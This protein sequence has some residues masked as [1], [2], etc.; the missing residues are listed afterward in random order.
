MV[1][2]HL[3]REALR[4]NLLTVKLPQRLGRGGKGGNGERYYTDGSHDPHVT[5]IMDICI[6]F[7]LN[8]KR[9]YHT[10]L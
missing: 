1:T 9:K 2:E 6:S 10:K 3:L 7:V 5:S 4:V 8:R